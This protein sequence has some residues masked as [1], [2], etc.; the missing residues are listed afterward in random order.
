MHEQSLYIIKKSAKNRI[1]FALL[2]AIVSDSVGVLVAS[3]SQVGVSYGAISLWL[4][5]F[6][7]DYLCVVAS[8]FFIASWLQMH[9]FVF[10][11]GETAPTRASKIRFALIM[12]LFTVS[13]ACFVSLVMKIGLVPELIPRFI[14]IFPAAYLT[15]VPFILIVAPRLQRCVDSLL[16][17]SNSNVNLP[18]N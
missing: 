10:L 13:I 9:I 6:P 12:A 3:V 2:M 11:P 16:S 5:I 7:V 18:A 8:I 1:I 15:A 14:G 17:D 4:S